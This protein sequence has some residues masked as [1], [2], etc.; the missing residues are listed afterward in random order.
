MLHCH[1]HILS[2]TT[3]AWCGPTCAA[4]VSAEKGA[5]I[6]TE[7]KETEGGVVMQAEQLVQV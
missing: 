2:S 3:E 6:C 1:I 5:S 4:L 7:Y